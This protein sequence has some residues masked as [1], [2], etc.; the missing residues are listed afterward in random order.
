M[1]RWQAATVTGNMETGQG[2]E[3]YIPALALAIIDLGMG[4]DGSI[5][6]SLTRCRDYPKLENERSRPLRGGRP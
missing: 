1:S 4:S 6:D 2:E 5:R 3:G